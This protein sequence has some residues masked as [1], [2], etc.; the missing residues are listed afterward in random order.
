[1]C[2]AY[3]KNG[4]VKLKKKARK[5][6]LIFIVII[7]LIFTACSNNEKQVDVAEDKIKEVEDKIK[8]EYNDDVEVHGNIKFTVN[9]K[10]ESTYMAVKMLE[11]ETGFTNY[12]IS[13]DI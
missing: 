11:K 2:R 9:P 6:T 3:N 8:F 10:I 1:M 5:L 13:G 4:G 12:R 7:L